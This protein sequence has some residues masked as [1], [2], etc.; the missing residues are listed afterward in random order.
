MQINTLSYDVERRT[1]DTNNALIGDGNRC[2]TA[3][4]G[5][6]TDARSFSLLNWNFHFFFLNVK[7][8]D[9]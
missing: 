5:W 3:D 8:Q 7:M 4:E 1:N 6:N 9:E 2:A